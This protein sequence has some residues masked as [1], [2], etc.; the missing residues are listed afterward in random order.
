MDFKHHYALYLIPNPTGVKNS[1]SEKGPDSTYREYKHLDWK[2]TQTDTQ[3]QESRAVFCFGRIRNSDCERGRD[4]TDKEYK[5][6]DWKLL[7]AAAKTAAMATFTLSHHHELHIAL[8]RWLNN[9]T[10]TFCELSVFWR[11]VRLCC[12]C[13]CSSLYSCFFCVCQLYQLLLIMPDGSILLLN[14]IIK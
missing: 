13:Y 10:S 9:V 14:Y 8:Q 11:P 7:Q 3:T 12:F 1:D 6:L 2:L 5:H 4:S